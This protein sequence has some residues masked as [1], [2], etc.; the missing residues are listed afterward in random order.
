MRS[1]KERGA[2]QPQNRRY[3]GGG[4]GL[5]RVCGATRKTS[6]SLLSCVARG[7]PQTRIRA[8]KRPVVQLQ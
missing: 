8:P 7:A 6:V 4:G 1:K 3:R 5:I 2:I